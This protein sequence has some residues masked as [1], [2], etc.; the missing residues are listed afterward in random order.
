[1]DF[2]GPL[3]TGVYSFQY[4]FVAVDNF[5]RFV[6]LFPLK[7]ATAKACVHK[8]INYYFSQYGFPQ[9]IIFGHGRQFISHHWQ[10]S[11]KKYNV[12]VGH[13]SV[14]HPQTNPAKRVM[15][16][17]RR[18]FRTYCNERHSAWPHLP[19]IEWVLNNVGH[20]ATHHTPTELWIFDQHTNPA[21][22]YIQYPVFNVSGNNKKKL[23]LA[24]QVQ[25][26]KAEHHKI[27]HDKRLHPDP[28]KVK[29]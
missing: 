23:T 17:L 25:L 4:I 15:R 8:L 28:F 1:M 18:M 19:Y 14:Y 21:H 29:D 26:T 20:K 3:P 16:E 27:R 12:T 10:T 9:N 22:Q 11:L 5:S 24:N 7:K 2:Y 13:T 6:K